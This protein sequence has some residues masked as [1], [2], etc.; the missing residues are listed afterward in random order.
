MPDPRE[1]VAAHGHLRR[2]VLANESVVVA[3]RRH[4]A[5]LLEPILTTVVSFLAIGAIVQFVPPGS[6]DGFQWLWILWFLVLGRLMW[7]WLVWYHEWFVATDKRLLLAYGLLVHKVAMMP[8]AKVTDMGYSRTPLGQVI[9]YGRFV[10]ESAG[11]EQ[12]L[13][14]VD[15]VPQPDSTYRKLVAT[16]FQPGMQEGFPQQ[17]GGT[18]GL[19]RPP[20]IVPPP[21]G[22]GSRPPTEEIPVVPTGPR[23]GAG[24]APGTPTESGSRTPGITREPVSAHPIP[25]QPESS[26][27]GTVVPK[28]FL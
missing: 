3:T 5:K 2:F 26:G 12:A 11:Q 28:P 9:G 17:P 21:R 1:A 6:R 20:A 18:A 14:Q 23:P 4:W 13:R 8:L 7:K 19:Y 27:G 16:I 25:G 22:G 24:R 10:M 15:W